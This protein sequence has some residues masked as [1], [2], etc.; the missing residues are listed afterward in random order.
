MQGKTDL[1]AKETKGGRM[2]EKGW[3]R[4]IENMEKS[5]FVIFLGVQEW[6]R[7]VVLGVVFFNPLFLGRNL[8]D[9]HPN[10]MNLA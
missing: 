6:P 7:Y 10:P 9:S 5:I 2:P 8:C 1:D 4:S 3:R